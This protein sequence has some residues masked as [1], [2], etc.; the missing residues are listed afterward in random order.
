MGDQ[1]RL[2]VSQWI[3]DW[4]THRSFSHNYDNYTKGQHM[5]EQNLNNEDQ[6]GSG[7]TSDDVVGGLIK[8]SEA[9]FSEMLSSFGIK[10]THKRHKESVSA[11]KDGML[12]MLRHLK[13]MGVVVV[14]DTPKAP[15]QVTHSSESPK[16]PIG[17]QR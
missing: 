2:A 4:N 13:E 10:P 14:I 8:N 6:R 11:F 17:T 5:S 1:L 3:D 9:H 12:T 15:K 7:V 16:V